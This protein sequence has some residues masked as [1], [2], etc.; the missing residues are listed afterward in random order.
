MTAALQG[1]EWSAAHLGR[2]LPTGKSGYLFYKRLG[3]PKD[4]LD[5]LKTSSLPGFDPEPSNA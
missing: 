2:T 5:G 3:G 4:G 1:G